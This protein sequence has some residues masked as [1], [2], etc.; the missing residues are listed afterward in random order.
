M[1]ALARALAAF[2]R[3]AELADVV[4]A[5]ANPVM[6]MGDGVVAVDALIV[7]GG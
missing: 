7:K 5:D 6:V 2:S 4:E 1:A 3:L